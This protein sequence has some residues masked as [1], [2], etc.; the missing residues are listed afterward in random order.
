MELS[1]MSQVRGGERCRWDSN[2]RGVIIG[3]NYGVREWVGGSG[4]TAES[5]SL[6]LCVHLKENEPVKLMTGF[7]PIGIPQSEGTTMH[8]WWKI[9]C[10]SNE[11]E[12]LENE[13]WNHKIIGANHARYIDGLALRFEESLSNSTSHNSSAILKAGYN[14]YECVSNGTLTKGSEKRKSVDEPAKVGRSGR[15]VKKAKGGEIVFTFAIQAT[16]VNVVDAR[17]NQRA[18]YECGDPNHLRNVCPK[19]NQESRQYGNQI[20]LGWRRNERGGGN[21]VSGRAYNVSMNAAET[22][23]D[24]SVVTGTFSLNDHFATVLF[25]SGVDFSF[26]STKFALILNMKP[27]IA[28]PVEFRIELIPGATP[29]AKSPYR[30]APSEMQ[31]LSEQLKELQDKGF[32]HPSHSPWGAPVLFVKKKDGSMRMCIDY[33]E[34]NKLTVKNRY[35]LPRIDDLFDQLQGARYFSKIDLRSGY[36]Q[37]RVH[38]DDIPKTAFRTSEEQEAAF[39]TLK[40]NLSDAPVLSLPDGV[41]I[42]KFTLEA[43][44][45]G[46]GCVLMQRDNVIAYASRQLKIH[47]KNYTTHDL[48]LGAVVFALKT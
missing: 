12:R 44:N 47:E 6:L 26:I 13:F 1:E 35:P 17:P 7:A 10:P 15:D 8:Y 46:L 42:F 43:S 21:Q 14:D 18:C 34:L 37:L 38:E 9:F 5:E 11:M 31:E 41:K 39:Q 29:V 36:H 4:L 20:A 32:I 24:S 3:M 19:L 48:E 45:Q 33:H 28:N 23:K 25:D 40:N 2:G 22:A 27:S 16:P 30:L